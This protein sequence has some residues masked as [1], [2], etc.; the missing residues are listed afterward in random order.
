MIEPP[1]PHREARLVDEKPYAD[2]DDATK[3]A[4]DASTAHKPAQTG[5]QSKAQN[6]VPPADSGFSEDEFINEFVNPHAGEKQP[7]FISRCMGDATM[8]K[9]FP[10]QKQRAAVC[11]SYWRKS[12][13]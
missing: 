10:D 2:T 7:D 12:K 13:K 3:K 8:N 9:E 1:I 11:Y 5:N 6:E 4:V